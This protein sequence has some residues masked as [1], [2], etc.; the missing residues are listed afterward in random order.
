MIS[1]AV[2][3]RQDQLRTL[4]QH[5]AGKKIGAGILPSEARAMFNMY[6]GNLFLALRSDLRRFQPRTQREMLNRR[7]IRAMRSGVRLYRGHL[8]C[9]LDYA[10]R[11]WS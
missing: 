1:N 2:L 11:L 9:G 5:Y 6:R 8:V 10:T 7:Q 3:I 4:C